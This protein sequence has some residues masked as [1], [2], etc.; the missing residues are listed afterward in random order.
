MSHSNKKDSLTTLQNIMKDA[1]A[2]KESL[3]KLPLSM[4]TNPQ[5]K[6]Y[7]K[8][9]SLNAH[10]YSIKNKVSLFDRSLKEL[11]FKIDLFDD[12]LFCTKSAIIKTMNQGKYNITSLCY[13]KAMHTIYNQIEDNYGLVDANTALKYISSNFDKKLFE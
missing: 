9:N 6:D 13:N 10:L 7:I 8:E 1:S 11:T 12:E 5:E 2:L 4:Q 3:N